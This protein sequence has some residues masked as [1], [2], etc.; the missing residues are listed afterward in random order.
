MKRKTCIGAIIVVAMLAVSASAA[1]ASPVWKFNGTELT[2]N[3]KLVGAAVSS[4]LTI[5]GV[6]TVC[7][8]FLYQLKAFN[9]GG[10][11]KG[12]VTELP[13]YECGTTSGVCSVES[14][15][16]KGF[17]WAS[18]LVTVGSNKY[19]I[20]EGVQVN[21]VY[22]GEMCAIA[23]TLIKLTG[24]AGGITNNAAQSV[25]FNGT[26]FSATGTSLKVGASSVEW[27]GVFTVEPFESK[28]GQLVEVI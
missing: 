13:L 12:E 24:T 21:I 11:G 15:T 7:Q 18:H 20:I 16:P 25:T 14:I 17:P 23:G 4:S 3:E 8:H 2:G 5:P 1:M 27:N 19:V 6:T 10:T 26:T 22:S 28:R 9:S